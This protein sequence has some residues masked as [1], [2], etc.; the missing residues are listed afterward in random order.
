[1]RWCC[2]LMTL[3][4]AIC[5]LP[6]TATTSSFLSSNDGAPKFWRHK[7]FSFQKWCCF[8]R[9]WLLLKKLSQRK[10]QKFQCCCFWKKQESAK[11]GAMHKQNLTTYL[12]SRFWRKYMSPLEIRQNKLNNFLERYR[13]LFQI[14]NYFNKSET[15]CQWNKIYYEKK[16]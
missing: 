2:R 10:L 1:M 9:Q 16:V 12:W 4:M 5:M 6:N 13:R 14:N 3:D 7:L 15:T 11:A 8:R